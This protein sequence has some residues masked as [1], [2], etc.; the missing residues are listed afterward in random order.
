M[1]A[2]MA[3]KDASE[4]DAADPPAMNTVCLA[5][6]IRQSSRISSASSAATGMPCATGWSCCARSQETASPTWMRKAEA[7]AM[8]LLGHADPVAMALGR[9]VL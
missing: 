3:G 6:M 4:A 5:R 8:A 7:A 1:E 2:G 9:A